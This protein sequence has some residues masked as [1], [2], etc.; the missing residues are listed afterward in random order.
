MRGENGWTR[1]ARRVSALQASKTISAAGASR[2]LRAGCKRLLTTTQHSA[3]LMALQNSSCSLRVRPLALIMEQQI[4]AI[5]DGAGSDQSKVSCALLFVCLHSLF[6][7]LA[8]I[9]SLLSSPLLSS[10]QPVVLIAGVAGGRQPKFT[11]T[12]PFHFSKSRPVSFLRRRW[13]RGS[14]A[15]FGRGL[16]RVRR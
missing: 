4:L 14:R 1:A 2:Q 6:V 8:S 15:I 5:V 3:V 9:R 7:Q 16:D 13:L 11:T 12:I 10:S